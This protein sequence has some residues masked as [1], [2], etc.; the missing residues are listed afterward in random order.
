M[1]SARVPVDVDSE[2]LSLAGFGKSRPVHHAGFC[3]TNVR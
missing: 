3:T 1:L 2:G